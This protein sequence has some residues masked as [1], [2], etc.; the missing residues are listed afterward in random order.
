MYIITYKL[1]NKIEKT[2]TKMIVVCK[3]KKELESQKNI[4][5]G[6]D[7]VRDCVYYHAKE[8]SCN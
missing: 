1:L 6:W 2:N 7:G 5:A 8:I 4:L 3:N